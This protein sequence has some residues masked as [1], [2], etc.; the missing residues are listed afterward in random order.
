M[1]GPDP[2]TRY[3]VPGLARIAFLKNLITLP[4]I[5]VG[6]YTYYDDPVDP[7]GF[8]RHCVLYHSPFDGD[9]LIIGSL[10]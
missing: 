5:E 7:A 9:R 8:E 3:P 1:L 10:S 6:E 2:D 4:Y